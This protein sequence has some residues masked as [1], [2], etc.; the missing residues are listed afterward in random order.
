[1]GPMLT[2]TVGHLNFQLDK[3]YEQLEQQKYNRSKDE[4]ILKLK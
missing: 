3:R 4:R 1:M 2:H